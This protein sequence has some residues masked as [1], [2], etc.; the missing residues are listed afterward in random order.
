MSTPRRFAVCGVSWS[1]IWRR[2]ASSSS[3]RFSRNGWGSCCSR[4]GR[5]FPKKAGLSQFRQATFHPSSPPFSGFRRERIRKRVSTD[6]ILRSGERDVSDV[7]F[8]SQPSRFFDCRR[9][10]LD[11]TVRTSGLFAQQTTFPT[12]DT[13]PWE[14]SRNVDWRRFVSAHHTYFADQRVR[15]DGNA[16][17]AAGEG[18]GDLRPPHHGRDARTRTRESTFPKISV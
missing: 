10:A 4:W 7:S 12:C 13:P 8:F 3:T 11:T 14:S 9:F 17:G 5:R 15:E 18:E 1:N 6:Q 16:G 2:R